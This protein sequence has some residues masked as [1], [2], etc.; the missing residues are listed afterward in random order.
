MKDKLIKWLVVFSF[1]TPLLSAALWWF[2]GEKEKA[3]NNL[4]ASLGFIV[5]YCLIKEKE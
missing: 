2:D 5:A 4:R 3:Y 1:V